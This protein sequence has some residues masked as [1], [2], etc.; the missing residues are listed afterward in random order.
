MEISELLSPLVTDALRGMIQHGTK[1]HADNKEMETLRVV[2]REQLRRE[3]R[4]NAE[5]MKEQNLDINVRV[6]NLE[7]DALDIAFN[8]GVPLSILLNRA[9]SEDTLRAAAGESKAHAAH[10]LQLKTE[11]E[12]IERA[13]H[14]IRMVKIRAKYGLGLGDVA[15]LRK[16]IVASHLSL[17]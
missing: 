5:L 3:L 9:L 17:S 15:Y 11:A 14:R 7:T 10:L 1:S 8:Q 6:L 16:L 2:V 12:L 13:L 4:Y